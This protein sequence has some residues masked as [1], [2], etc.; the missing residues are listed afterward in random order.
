MPGASGPIAE[1]FA[2]V[3]D[4]ASVLAMRDDAPEQREELAEPAAPEAAQ[5]R[6][7][8]RT[9]KIAR[10]LS[11][12]GWMILAAAATL[13]LARVVEFSPPDEVRID[14]ATVD[15]VGEAPAQ[16]FSQLDNPQAV[17]LRATL[18]LY[19]RDD[20]DVRE[21]DPKL[22]DKA[23]TLSQPVVTTIY[24]MNATID[25]TVRLDGGDLEIDVSLAG[26]PRLGEAGKNAT[27]PVNLEHEL[28]IVSREHK[29]LGEPVH[30]THLHT[31]GTLAE[32]EE[33]PHRWVFTIDG[34]LFALD[35]EL[36]R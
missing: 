16:E 5:A 27:P 28:T 10:W 9:K 31:R 25:Q 19:P 4:R 35:L 29:W 23:R 18:R 32:L 26:T 24:A 13:V 20:L 36:H 12:N 6:S 22:D 11:S 17:Q 33:R 7:A 14:D 1:N 2:S 34:K 3:H 21:P 8:T 30:R 15:L